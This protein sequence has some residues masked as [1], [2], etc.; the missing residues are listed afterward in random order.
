M[1]NI[2]TRNHL[3][4][5]VLIV[6]LF[7][8][9]FIG[10]SQKVLLKTSQPNLPISVQKE[11]FYNVL[12]T[13]FV[14]ID[15]GYYS[16]S[17]NQ[18]LVIYGDSVKRQRTRM[19]TTKEIKDN[20]K[21]IILD[22]IAFLPQKTSDLRSIKINEVSFNINRNNYHINFY[23]EYKDYVN[24]NIMHTSK[25]DSDIILERSEFS[26]P[27]NY[28]LA[29][30]NYL[31]TTNKFTMSDINVMLLEI[32]VN[33]IT[34]NNFGYYMNFVVGGEIKIVNP[35]SEMGIKTYKFNSS[36]NIKAL[37]KGDGL[38]NELMEDAL[39]NALIQFTNNKLYSEEFRNVEETYNKISNSW[40][41]LEISNKKAK[42][43]NG[44]KDAVNAVV[45]IKTKDG[46]GS[47]CIISSDGYIITNSHVVG[48]QNENIVVMMGG[49]MFKVK[50]KVVRTN[51]VYD[52][53]L[54][55]VDSLFT[56][57]LVLE[58]TDVSIG[59]DVYAIGTP[60]DIELG[61]TISKGIISGKRKFD[62]KVY[63]QTDVSVNSGNSGGALIDLEGKLIGIIN[64]KLFGFGVEGVG[65]AIPVSVV[66]PALKVKIN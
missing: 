23:E 8:I 3:I 20:K 66:E 5:T 12:E 58:N 36:S 63:I 54:I 53:A 42:E 4:R 10:S 35:M 21:R 33:N 34:E 51:P 61:Q 7:L 14:G 30:N 17:S 1:M 55:K 59:S 38:K 19:I 22:P 44:L 39:M 45:T 32:K 46:H 47:G 2:I 26:N 11:D 40:Q 43:N 18:V 16:N 60:E 37:Q 24:N 56:N 27:L 6:F 31:D 62:G 41:I 9:H 52:L 15:S 49:T 25:P 29:K 48:S 50:G 28:I 64:A 57:Y 65:F 13:T